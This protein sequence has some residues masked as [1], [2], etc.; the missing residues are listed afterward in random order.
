GGEPDQVPA[1]GLGQQ[2]VAGVLVPGERG[3]GR[4]GPDPNRAGAR[5]RGDRRHGD[6]VEPGGLRRAFVDAVLAA[7]GPGLPLVL[8]RG[9]A[10]RRGGATADTAEGGLR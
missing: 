10:T 4:R 3:G 7:A 6:L 8:D 1:L 2:Q 9:S 5:G